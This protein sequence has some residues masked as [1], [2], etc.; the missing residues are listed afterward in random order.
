MAAINNIIKTLAKLDAETLN[1]LIKEDQGAE[2]VCH[3]CKTKYYF[4]ATELQ[5]ILDHKKTTSR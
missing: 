4:T 3:Y 1:T 5:T 2:V